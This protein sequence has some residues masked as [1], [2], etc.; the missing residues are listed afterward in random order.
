MLPTDETSGNREC[1]AQYQ[2]TYCTEPNAFAAV[3][4]TCVHV[5]AEALKNAENTDA[6]SIR[7]TLARIQNLDT[8]RSVL[9]Q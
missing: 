6:Q 1:V 5:F 9:F 7:D 8:F 3:P 4:Y 2:K